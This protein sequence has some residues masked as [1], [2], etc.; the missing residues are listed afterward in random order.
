M[1]NSDQNHTHASNNP[2]GQ[3]QQQPQGDTP[4]SGEGIDSL[5]EHL[6]TQNRQRRRITAGQAPSR[7]PDDGQPG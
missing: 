5:I 3:Q 7:M 4:H 2:Q 1:D 6:G